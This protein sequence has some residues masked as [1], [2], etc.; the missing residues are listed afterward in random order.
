MAEEF[1]ED[2]GVPEVPPVSPGN[3]T[4]DQL[5]EMMRKFDAVTSHL[6]RTQEELGELRQWR[7][8][9]TSS[10]GGARSTG[11]D[12]DAEFYKAPTQRLREYGEQLAGEI[13][14][15]VE[16]RDTQREFWA[17]FEDTYPDLRGKRW[18]V[19][20]VL[21]EDAELRAMPVTSGRE[22]L[23]KRTRARLLGLAQEMQASR[24]SQG[25]MT[26]LPGGAGARES[27]PVQEEPVPVQSIS[28]RLAKL[29]QRGRA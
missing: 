29:H 13:M 3:E 24:G 22:E 28:E 14:R 5:R 19:A 23:A 16:E 20:A 2:G 7:E 9:V 21:Q 11:Q 18:V 12:A 6:Q 26:V 1:V 25:G 10:L 17:T 15:R 4:A 27:R 8:G